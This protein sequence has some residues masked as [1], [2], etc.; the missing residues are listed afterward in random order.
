MSLFFTVKHLLAEAKGK[1][2]AITINE[3]AVR[4]STDRRQ[5]EILLETRLADF[6]FALVAGSR[7]YYRP[8]EQGEINH[9][10]RDLCSRINCIALRIETVKHQAIQ[11]GWVYEGGEFKA[12]PKQMYFL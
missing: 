3:L 11:E 9:Y 6:G 8:V 7:G 12:Q 2:N 5:I 4:A 10:I 1:T